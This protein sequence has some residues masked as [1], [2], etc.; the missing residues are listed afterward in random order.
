ML[1][2]FVYLCC[3]WTRVI[4]YSNFTEN[5]YS[6]NK[7]DRL[8]RIISLRFTTLCTLFTE[9]RSFVVNRRPNRRFRF[10]LPF[11][12][13]DTNKNNDPSIG[14]NRANNYSKFLLLGLFTVQRERRR[15]DGEIIWKFDFHKIAWYK[16]GTDLLL[17]E[18]LWSLDKLLAGSLSFPR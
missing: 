16:I 2:T 3:K 14:I 8:K 12:S 1:G 9:Y 18:F 10:G 17:Y 13:N 15:K 4:I 7:F 6:S 5:C 11:S